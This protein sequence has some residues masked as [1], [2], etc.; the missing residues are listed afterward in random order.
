M[1]PE[2]MDWTKLL[3][4]VMTLVGVI[5]TALLTYLAQRSSKKT[6]SN[7]NDINKAVNRS[8]ER[9]VMPLYDAVLETHA[10]LRSQGA[11]LVEMSSSINGIHKR[12][13]SGAVLMEDL[14]QRIR[15]IEKTC[16]L[17]KKEDCNAK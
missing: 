8:K 12:L 4:G 11:K 10:E 9:N 2:T 13:E 5:I 15:F 17:N 7:T 3:L 14:G 1:T 6:L 16:P